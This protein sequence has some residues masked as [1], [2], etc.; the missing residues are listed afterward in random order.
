MLWNVTNLLLKI[1][2]MKA[3]KKPMVWKKIFWKDWPF[4]KRARGDFY[5]ERFCR[6]S[7]R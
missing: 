3:T 6:K 1:I 2:K 5:W 7:E 4:L